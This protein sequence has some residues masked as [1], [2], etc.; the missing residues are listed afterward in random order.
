MWPEITA[1]LCILVIALLLSL[2]CSR[3]PKNNTPQLP[4]GP[5]GLPLIGHLHLLGSLPHHSLHKLSQ[6]H[7]PIMFLRLGLIPTIVLT[8]PEYTELFLKTHDSIFASRPQ[9]QASKYLSYG[10]KNLVFAQYGSYWR[11]MRKLCTIELLSSSKIE[12]FRSMRYEEVCNLVQFL[13]NGSQ[14]GEGIDLTAK[15]YSVIEDMTYRMILGCKDRYNFKSTLQETVRLAGLVNVSDYIPFLAPLDLQGLGRQLKATSK[16]LDVLLE[17]I[18]EEHVANPKQ[19]Q[20][21]DF[22]DVMLSLMESN[23]TRELQLNRD[24]IKAIILDMLAGSVDTSSTSI[25]WT[26]AELLK[27]PRVMKVLQNE[28]EDVVGRDR[29]VEETDLIKLDY[30]KMVIKETMRIHPIAPLLIPHESTEDITVNGYFIPKKSRVLV[31]TWA[32]G[33]DPNV[34]S[35]NAEE[36]YPERFIGANMDV[37][38]HDF[39]FIPFGTGRRKCPGLQL[40]FIVVQLVVAQLVHCFN[41]EL[42]NGKSGD[43]LDMDE[44]F[45]LSVPRANHLIVVPRYRLK[46]HLIMQ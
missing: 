35:E 37:E 24:N 38:G 44:R 1:L 30:L 8:S 31:N 23:N 2:P 32:I 42:P 22:T 14:L 43:D 9:I 25:E 45:G 11:S 10:Y 28:L 41:L 20:D 17:K 6:K 12:S 29:M 34:W 18:I 13:K 46:P 39:R 19:Q 4:P 3:K 40:G 21:K 7:G 27:N 5:R 16:A 33:R 26:I 36:F 15:I